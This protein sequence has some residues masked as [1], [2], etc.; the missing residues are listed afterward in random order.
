MAAAVADFRPAHPAQ[1]QDQEG[2]RACPTIELEP[3]DDV[4]ERC[5]RSRRRP[6]QLLVGFAA[7]HGE[8]ALEY[9]RE[10]LRPKGLDAVVVND[11]SRPGH[12]LRRR[13]E[14]GDD[15]HRRRTSAAS[16]RA[17]RA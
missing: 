6:G 9:G 10:K 13:G 7:E 1:H 14:R 5:W 17:A 12:R 3:T 8:R 2:R 15:R 16:R 4:L 11:V